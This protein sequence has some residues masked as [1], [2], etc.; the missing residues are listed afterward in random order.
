MAAQT[1]IGELI[2][3]VFFKFQTRKNDGVEGISE[4]GARKDVP[5]QEQARPE[6]LLLKGLGTRVRVTHWIFLD[7]KND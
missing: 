7:C 3:G 5:L 2:I 1:F 6:L 4:N